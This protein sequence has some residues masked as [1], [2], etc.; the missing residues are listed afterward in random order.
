MWREA[1]PDTSH[2]SESASLALGDALIC[3]QQSADEAS[4]YDA[5]TCFGVDL[6]V[7]LHDLQPRQRYRRT[8][9]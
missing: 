8:A 9:A 7:A 6:H 2:C 5:P 1:D 3:W 4:L